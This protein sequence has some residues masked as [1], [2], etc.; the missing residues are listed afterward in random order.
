MAAGTFTDA[1]AAEKGIDDSA[2]RLKDPEKGGAYDSKAASVR[3]SAAFHA[4]VES[5]RS[6][7][8]CT[9]AHHTTIP[10]QFTLL[11]AGSCCCPAHVMAVTAKQMPCLPFEG[12]SKQTRE[13][14]H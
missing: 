4:E 11:V 13:H 12:W 3:G 8:V 6:I 5:T 7:K 2:H 10:D 9:Q 1:P 14:I